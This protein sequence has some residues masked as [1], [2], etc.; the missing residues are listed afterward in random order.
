MSHLYRE[1]S[2]NIYLWS[3]SAWC[4]QQNAATPPIVVVVKKDDTLRI[5]V[6]YRQL[7]QMKNEDVYS[8]PESM[9]SSHLCTMLTAFRRWIC[10]CARSR[11]PYP[12]RIAQKLIITH[13]GLFFF[14]MMPFWLCNAPPTM[15]RLLH[16]IFRRESGNDLAAYLDYLLLY[17]LC[18]G[19]MLCIIKRTVGQLMDIALTCRPRKYFN[20]SIQ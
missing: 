4:T 12:C 14:N 6:D 13:K 17:A 1:S 8:L 5:C 20:H 3:G 10:S 11:F 7:N 2:T 16:G 19:E 18:D 9:R 15:Q